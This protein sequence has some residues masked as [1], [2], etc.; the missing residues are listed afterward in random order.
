MMKKEIQSRFDVEEL[1]HT[2]YVEVRKDK[3]LGPIFDHMIQREEL[4][5]HH[6]TKLVDFWEVNLLKTGK[7]EGTPIELHLW[8]DMQI[9]YKMNQ[10]HFDR[11]LALWHENLNL[12]FTG[13][14]AKNA[15]DR[16]ENIGKRIHDRVVKAKYR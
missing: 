16:A 4:W 10:T 7:Y 9:S 8:V 3:L 14:I 15:H 13:E 2:F 6:L 1:V 12:R 5:E 11:W